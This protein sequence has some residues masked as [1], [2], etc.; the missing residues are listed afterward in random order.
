MYYQLIQKLL[1]SKITGYSI[2]KHTG[3]S[4]TSISRLRRGLMDI[5]RLLL[6][7]AYRLSRFAEEHKSEL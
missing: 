6:G 5:D 1:D 7:H 3:V 2:E 4:R